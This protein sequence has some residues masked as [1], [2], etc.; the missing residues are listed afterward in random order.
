MAGVQALEPLRQSAGMQT[1]RV[2]HHARLHLEGLA[3]GAHLHHRR[4]ARPEIDLLDLRAQRQR[5]TGALHVALQRQHQRVAVDDAGAG[6]P[7]RLGGMHLGLVAAQGGRVPA[8][9]RHAVGTGAALEALQGRVLVAVGRHHHLAAGPVRHAA[10]GA[11]GV[12]QLLAAHT[13][14]RLGAAGG[15]VQAGVDDFAVARTHALADAIGRLN[16]HGLQPAQRQDTRHG[17]PHH[18]GA[19]HQRVNTIH[20]PLRGPSRLRSSRRLSRTARP[21]VPHGPAQAVP[22]HPQKSLLHSR[23]VD[24][25]A[26]L[27]G[28]AGWHGWPGWTGWHCRWWPGCWA[29]CCS[30]GCPSRPG[31]GRPMRWPS[32]RRRCRRSGP[33]ALASAAP[34]PRDGA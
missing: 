15:V 19:Y 11:I 12:E 25:R 33:G 28:T 7:Q 26:A 14:P 17:Q 2:D 16:D 18:S 21:V 4:S 34:P 30:P 9:H 8:L 32:R 1:R 6:R 31:S 10:A 24:L 22:S 23:R 20:S 29:G 27:A 13:Q 3:F 5:T